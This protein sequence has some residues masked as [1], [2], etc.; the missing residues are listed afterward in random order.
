MKRKRSKFSNEE[1]DDQVLRE[2]DDE[3]YLGPPQPPK[4]RVEKDD[5][6][7]EDSVDLDEKRLR[8]AQ[9]YLKRISKADNLQDHSTRDDD[10][11]LTR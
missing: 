11:F 5:E 3:E 8:L 4:E 2:E 7:E 9:G 10:A 1:I 6:E